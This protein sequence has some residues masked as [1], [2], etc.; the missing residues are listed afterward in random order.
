MRHLEKEWFLESTSFFIGGYTLFCAVILQ[1]LIDQFLKRSH[2]IRA[3]KI[4]KDEYFALQQQLTEF[5]G[6]MSSPADT[7]H[8]ILSLDGTKSWLRKWY[9][10]DRLKEHFLFYK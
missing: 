2:I 1:H 9:T 3:V 6:T 5:I 4:A 7:D 10:E 8:L